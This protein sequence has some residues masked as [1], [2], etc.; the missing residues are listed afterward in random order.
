MNTSTILKTG[1]LK[2]CKLFYVHVF[3]ITKQVLQS[4]LY[5]LTLLCKRVAM[6][7]MPNII[8]PQHAYKNRDELYSS[9]LV[10]YICREFNI[11]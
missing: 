3:C 4:N 1:S 7:T 2:M 5:L 8:M 6:N 9:Q 10:H 11:H